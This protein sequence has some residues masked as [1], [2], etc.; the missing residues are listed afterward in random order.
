[1]I[2]EDGKPSDDDGFD[3]GDIK[4][5]LK[6]RLEELKKELEDALEAV[7]MQTE[8]VMQPKGLEEYFDYYCYPSSVTDYNEQ[9]KY[10][11][12]NAQKRQYLYDAI[13]RLVRVYAELAAD[14]DKVYNPAEVNQVFTRVHDYE[15]TRRALMLRSGD[16][17]DF[18]VYDAEMRSLIDRYVMAGEI[19]EID[20]M[21][22]FSFLDYISHAIEETEPEEP[23][24]K[25]SRSNAETM[26][27]NTRRYV[28]RR[29]NS[30]PNEY[31][32]LS[33][34]LER[35]IKDLEQQRID[36]AEF[37][38]KVKE[39]NEELVG[40]GP[41]GDPILQNFA[42]RALYDNLGSDL[43]LTK[44]II[45]VIADNISVGFRTVSGFQRRLKLAIANALKDTEY[46]PDVIYQ[47]VDHHP[48]QWT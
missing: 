48:E 29:R 3:T 2:G 32:R 47:I 22:E 41:V 30:N 34:R 21:D 35:L 14:I 12:K 45:Q 31:M 39:I 24:K 11:E 9:G 10:L 4:E 46:N 33:A 44:K 1:M 20:D 36:Y 6:N 16:S 26:I 19:D 7:E 37:L 43:D 38:R 18:K 42:Y 8:E 25:G 17:V 5:I 28:N 13:G 27:N 23:K 40:K 15:E